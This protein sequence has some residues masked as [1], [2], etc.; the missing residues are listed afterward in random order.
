MNYSAICNQAGSDARTIYCGGVMTGLSGRPMNLLYRSIKVFS[1]F[2]SERA[3]LTL[4]THTH[5]H[6]HTLAKAV[7][8]VRIRNCR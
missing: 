4:H 3:I 6:T 5:T 2:R 8:C 1:L 7:S